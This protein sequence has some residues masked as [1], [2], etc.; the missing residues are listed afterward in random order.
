MVLIHLLAEFQQQC[1][2]LGLYQLCKPLLS[3]FLKHHYD[4]NR[5]LG[6]GGHMLIVLLGFLSVYKIKCRGEIYKMLPLDFCSS[7]FDDSTDYQI[8]LSC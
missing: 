1:E 2:S 4:S 3:C 7:S 5:F 8:L 6:V